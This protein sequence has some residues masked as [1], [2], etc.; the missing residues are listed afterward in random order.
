MDHGT[1]IVAGICVLLKAGGLRNS[2]S[3]TIW[4]KDLVIARDYIAHGVRARAQAL[5][6]LE[7]GPE[8]EIERIQKLV[9]AV[10]HPAVHRT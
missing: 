3:A 2:S 7:L 10:G 5:I 8:A 4:G 9:N 1:R 6:T